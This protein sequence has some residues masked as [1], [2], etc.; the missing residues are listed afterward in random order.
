MNLNTY[1]RSMSHP[2]YQWSHGTTEQP[3]RYNAAET[4]G[5]RSARARRIGRSVGTA[6]VFAVLTIGV[7]YWA[8]FSTEADAASRAAAD[9]QVSISPAP[10]EYFPDQY[11]NQA[12]QAEEHIQAF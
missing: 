5:T 2:R 4:R 9:S 10:F 12:K 1:T 8:K 7:A 6:L 3:G 11:V